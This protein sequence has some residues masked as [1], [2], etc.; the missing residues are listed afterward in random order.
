MSSLMSSLLSPLTS[1]STIG[2]EATLA[3]SS[4]LSA[5]LPLGGPQI[6]RRSTALPR[7]PLGNLAMANPP[8]Q[9]LSAGRITQRADAAARLS[10]QV[11]NITET[12]LQVADGVVSQSVAVADVALSM[13]YQNIKDG[14]KHTGSVAADSQTHSV[15]GNVG[16]LVGVAFAA[17]E[18]WLSIHSLKKAVRARNEANEEVGR[19]QEAATAF[20]DKFQARATGATSLANARADLEVCRPVEE[21]FTAQTE[22]WAK[23][24]RSLESEINA[25]QVANQDALQRSRSR[26]LLLARQQ[27]R[28]SLQEK[29]EGPEKAFLD[30]RR[31]WIDGQPGQEARTRQL[32][33]FELAARKLD[34]LELAGTGLSDR[35]TKLALRQQALTDEL[36]GLSSS[37]H[38][39]AIARR[40]RAEAR[41]ATAETAVGVARAGADLVQSGLEGTHAAITLAGG[42][43]GSGLVA[44][45]QIAGAAAGG[46]AIV[47]GGATIGIAAYRLNKVTQRREAIERALVSASDQSNNEVL[48]HAGQHAVERR[49]TQIATSKWNIFK[50]VLGVAGGSLAIAAITATGVGALALGVAALGIGIASAATAI[51]MLCYGSRRG[52]ADVALRNEVA[53]EQART[54]A[55]ESL[56]NT[57]REAAVNAGGPVPLDEALD[58]EAREALMARNPYYAIHVFSELLTQ[59]EA[60]PDRKAALDFLEASGFTGSQLEQ[61]RLLSTEGATE[62]D[63][64][65]LKRTLASHLLV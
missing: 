26:L 32:D 45:S 20:E 5:L 54:D 24:L 51:G 12:V 37:A 30:E 42:A 52:K 63:K 39:Y 6:V 8:R 64:Q 17:G 4:R 47:A 44:A 38:R 53:T 1:R 55:L 29:L 59:A 33:T 11:A 2:G 25:P 22:A 15:A 43:S 57:A 3:P 48:R 62:E 61:V 10:G 19:Y 46:L 60:D 7:V 35:I 18:T 13:S 36:R 58:K 34:K 41:H 23:R 28:K 16:A 49:T 27:E 31:K 56:K 21:E 50:G 65:L 9:S 14:A 40:A